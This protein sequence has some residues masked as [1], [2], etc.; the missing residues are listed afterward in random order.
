MQLS[1]D[2]ALPQA[3]CSPRSPPRPL[4]SLPKMFRTPIRRMATAA[5][6][7]LKIGL[8]PADGIGKEVIPA[9]RTVL[10]ALGSDIPKPEFI[11][12]LAG[13]EVFTRSGSALPEETVE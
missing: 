6:Q 10:E 12:L 9:A 4:R 8:I 2:S 3:S 5:R 11:D 1:L 7:S 13:W